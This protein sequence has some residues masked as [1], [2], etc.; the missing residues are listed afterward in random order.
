MG[1][2]HGARHFYVLKIFENY[3]FIQYTEKYIIDYLFVVMGG[4]KHDI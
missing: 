1:L 2:C 3:A 4:E